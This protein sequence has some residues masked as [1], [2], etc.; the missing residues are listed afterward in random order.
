[1]DTVFYKKIKFKYKNLILDVK[2][3]YVI[4][5]NNILIKSVKIV[6]NNVNVSKSIKTIIIL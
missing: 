4:I 2:I 6:K 3:Q 5:I 1:M